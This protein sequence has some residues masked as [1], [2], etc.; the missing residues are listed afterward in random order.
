MRHMT[1]PFSIRAAVAD[2]RT[3]AKSLALSAASLLTAGALTRARA[4]GGGLVLRL[5]APTGPHP[6]GVT[7]LHLVD[8]SRADPWN[9]AIGV[10]EVMVSVHYPARSVRGYPR[11]PQLTSGVVDLF[12]QIDV[13]VHGLPGEGV[14]WA[15]TLTHGHL[16]APAQTGRRRPVLLYTPGGGDPRTLGTLLAE[17]LASRGYVVVAVDHPGEAG[18]V[19]FPAATDVRGKV[20]ETVLTGPP[21]PEQFRTMISTRLADLRFVLDRLEDLADGRG[22][23]AAGRA[24]PK[25]LRRALDPRRVGVYGHS[26]GGTA[27]AEAL[28][29][30]RRIGAAVVLEGYL[31]HPPQRPGET[32]ELFPVARYGVDRPLLLLGTDGFRD[33]RLDRSWAALLAHP[34]GC[35]RRAMIDDAGHWVFTDYAAMA[36]QLQA[37]GLMTAAARAGLVGTLPPARSVPTVRGHV[38]SFFARHLPAH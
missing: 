3:V 1:H 30:D 28:Y 17:E 15:A 9:S 36:P 24:L 19:E 38:R 12:R 14:D 32:G 5:P 8:T 33:E 10:R 20:R 34:R 2:R 23:D 25:G 16:D 21:T 7:A 18:A 37:A 31:D 29:E 35:A 13:P 22:P 26:A 27:A 11:V 6:V 4:A